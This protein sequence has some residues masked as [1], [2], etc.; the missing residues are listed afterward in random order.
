[1]SEAP[2]LEF[3]NNTEIIDANYYNESFK[4]AKEYM[5]TRAAYIFNNNNW[6]P[7]N[8]SIGTWSLRV[9]RS[10]IMKN[11]TE[12]DINK[13]GDESKYNKKRKA[14]VR[15]N[16]DGLARKRQRKQSR[17]KKEKEKQHHQQ[18]TLLGRNR[19]QEKQQEGNKNNSKNTSNTNN[20]SS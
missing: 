14:R 11:G 18:Q 5:K 9:Q 2:G 13:L 15:E 17:K 6:Q 3:K 8:W 20:N 19:L 10:S 16:E 7:D 1:M 4:T 12:D